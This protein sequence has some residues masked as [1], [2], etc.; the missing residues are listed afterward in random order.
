MP[1]DQ[2]AQY[3]RHIAERRQVT[4][5]CAFLKGGAV[6]GGYCQGQT[7]NKED[8]TVRT[9]AGGATSDTAEQGKAREGWGKLIQHLHELWGARSPTLV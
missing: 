1:K 2:K 7:V 9:C 4:Q 3:S 6:E 8:K 5:P